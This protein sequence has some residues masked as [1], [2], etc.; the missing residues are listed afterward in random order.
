MRA[1]RDLAILLIFTCLWQTLA[2]QNDK[3]PLP[4]QQP[5]QPG[6]E[7]LAMQY[8]QNKEYEKAVVLFEKLYEANRG[9]VYYQY[10]LHCLISLKDF[11]TAEKVVRKQIKKYPALLKYLVDLGYV[12]NESGETQKAQREFDEA[13]E[14]I[15]PDKNQVIEL[16]NAF[17]YRRE[18]N[19]AIETYLAGRKIVR[20]YTFH[21][22]LAN[23]YQQTGNPARMIDE[24]LDLLDADGEELPTV[25]SRLQSSLRD[26]PD[27]TLNNSLKKSLLKRVQANPDKIV[28]AE[29]L[30]W[31][32]IQQ[33]DFEQAFIQA[34]SIDRRLN[35]EG[36]R[37]YDLAGL[38]VANQ[39][40][41]IAIEAYTYVMKKGKEYPFYINSLVGMLNARFLKTTSVYPYPVSDL[42]ELEKEYYNT[43]SEFGKNQM[44]ISVIRYLGHL[45]AFFLSKPEDAI[46][47]LNET[48]S[49]RN[50][51]PEQQAECKIELADIL[52]MTGDVWEATLLYSQVEKAFKNDP[53]GHQ[54]KFKNAKLS[55]Y[56]GEFNWA[57]A[58]LDVLKAATSK[59]I[60]NDALDL[61]LLI[62][63]N[64]DAD[65]ST[66]PLARFMY[67]DLLL[68]RNKDDSALL[69]LDSL[70][71]MSGYHPI[72]DEVLYRMAEINMKKGLY[73]QAD[74]LLTL[75]IENYPQDLKADDALFLLA[76]IC[77]DRLN[78]LPRAMELYEKILV[79]YPGSLYTIEARKRY[80]ELRGDPLN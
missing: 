61:S 13:L 16:A 29:L 63:E 10:Y 74:S 31:L 39:A 76:G 27:F 40:Y 14:R 15:T 47:L 69:V 71:R 36:Q 24:Y 21:Y 17:Q 78:D 50:I 18:M 79:E 75:V 26:D 19:Y 33:K 54:A 20:D 22:E 9:E 37:V 2:A 48:V 52:L 35:E 80:R 30:I 66:V 7:Q 43:L 67:A 28:Y 41:D 59:L 57:K 42:L 58:Q 38:C 8:L 56:I 12:F 4:G 32:S 6:D 64:I 49:L 73:A 60:A 23:I 46:A 72:Q 11:R 68:F 77:R 44:T 62:T 45:Q 55:M 34:K 25:Q 70:R 5:R 3:P 1:F 53:I 51:T 65:S